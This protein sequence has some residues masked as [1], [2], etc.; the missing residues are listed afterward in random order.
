MSLVTVILTQD[1]CSVV[2]D[3]RISS[4]DG[5][6]RT[7]H[8]QKFRVFA[9]RF[10]IL[11]GGYLDPLLE[12]WRNL[13]QTDIE[14]SWAIVEEYLRVFMTKMVRWYVLANK[15]DRDETKATIVLCG[16]NDDGQ[17]AA[18]AFTNDGY[19]MYDKVFATPK[20]GQAAVI[21]CPP[22]E[23]PDAEQLLVQNISQLGIAD[24]AAQVATQQEVA[25]LA[26]SVN[27]Q[28]YGMILT[29][30]MEIRNL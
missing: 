13:E 22:S 23:Y 29:K 20:A 24:F 21:T 14:L 1:E 8:F 10:I 17:I 30:D 5:Q 19:G 28:S 9:G 11:G 18:H 2:S 16:I 27:E 12:F 15:Q 3:G 7:E 25:K 26:F 4:K 6:L